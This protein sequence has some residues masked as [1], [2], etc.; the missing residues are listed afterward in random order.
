MNWLKK[1]A[2]RWGYTRCDNC[3]ELTDYN[4]DTCDNCGRRIK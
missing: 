2:V 3:G 4:Y 1:M